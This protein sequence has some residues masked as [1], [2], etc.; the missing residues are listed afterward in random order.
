MPVLVQTLCQPEKSLL[1]Q[2]LE[3]FLAKAFRK[4][5]KKSG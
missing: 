5:A 2:Q 3:I 1:N 4:T